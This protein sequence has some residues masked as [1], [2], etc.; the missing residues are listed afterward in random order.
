MPS[1]NAIIDYWRSQDRPE[2]YSHVIGWGEP[3]CFACNWLPP[4]H[5]GRPDSW[6][7]AG[8]WLDKAHLHDRIDGGADEPHNLVPLCHL[9]H[10][11]MPAFGRYG[12]YKTAVDATAAA[13]QWVTD[14]P[15]KG[16]FQMWTDATLWGK[17]PNRATTLVRAKMRYL[18]AVQ[19]IRQ[20]AQ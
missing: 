7:K 8:S 16:F 11:A 5:D 20:D 19:Q 13:W 12:D 18:E 10:H 3:F 9:C 1:M 15:D 2:I 4:V 14:R 17:K 6:T